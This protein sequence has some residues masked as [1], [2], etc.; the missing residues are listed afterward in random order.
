V[1]SGKDGLEVITSTQL[2]ERWQVPERWIRDR[3][4]NRTPKDERIPCLRLG[5][6]VRFEWGSSRL[7][8]WLEKRRQ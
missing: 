5:R 1:E 2:A 4:R 8:D 3:T 6:Y 7:A